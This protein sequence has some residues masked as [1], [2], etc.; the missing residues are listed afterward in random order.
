LGLL[1]VWLAGT[2]AHI[3]CLGYVYDFSLRPE[4]VAPTIW[5]LLWTLRHRLTDF[6]PQASV[7]V[8]NS[9]FV[10]PLLAPFVAAPQPG[11]EVLLVL[12]L[13]NVAIYAAI[14]VRRPRHRLAFHLALISLASLIG[15]LPGQ[16]TQPVIGEFSY[17]KGLGTIAA[18]Y[19]MLCSL[20]SRN[21][22]LG[23]FG[24]L[25]F[26]TSIVVVLGDHAGALHWACQGGLVFLL[27]HSLRWDDATNRGSRALRIL[28][29]VL[30]TAHAFV[31][32][33]T[34][35]QPWMTCAAAAPL[36]AGYLIARTIKGKWAPLVLPI[37]A[38]IVILSGPGEAAAVKIQAAPGWMM[39]VLGSFILFALGTV[40]ALTKHRWLRLEATEK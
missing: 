38:V 5:M 25:V 6:A 9:L 29:G 17:S 39:A 23:I 21:P 19:F 30:W 27:I 40:A 16:W 36:L 15:G 7:A 12:T 18:G 34:G 31:W 35:A 1:S 37:T 32:T 24:S 28:V 8:Q 26:T 11:H 14:Y 33:C 10:G 4:L 13:L 20:L 3:Y 22:K 2:A